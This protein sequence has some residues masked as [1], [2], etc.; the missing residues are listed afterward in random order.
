MPVNRRTTADTPTAKR[1]FPVYF[2]KRDMRP[3]EES[4]RFAAKYGQTKKV[5]V[6]HFPSEND[7]KSKPG[8]TPQRPLNAALLLES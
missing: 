5:K 2:P 1:K 8:F 4:E 3:D 6:E 7:K